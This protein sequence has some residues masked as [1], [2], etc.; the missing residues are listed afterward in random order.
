MNIWKD[1]ILPLAITFFGVLLAL[2]VDKQRLPKISIFVSEDANSDNTYPSHPKDE[3]RWK[4]FRVKVLNKKMPYWFAWLAK[5]QTAESCRATISFIGINNDTNFT[6]KGR[7]ASTPEL[8]F[9][10]EKLVK[11]FQPDPVTIIEG[12]S[13]ILDVITK[14]EKDHEAYGWN[15][16]A[17]FHNWR[18][19]EYKLNRGKY[20]VKI[21][22]NT[23]N[24]VSAVKDFSLTVADTI[25][26]T[27][28]ENF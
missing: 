19:P 25:E 8:P 5:R 28:L 23:Q 17:Y 11:I 12:D 3:Q 24:G 18:T 16:E 1:L 14:C 9:L 27:K 4:Y 13:E 26:E 21:V 2:L 20:K 10:N 22:I 15:N 6:F 7:W